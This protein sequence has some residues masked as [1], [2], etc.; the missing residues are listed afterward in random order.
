MPN[1][2]MS[3]D[4]TL[5]GVTFNTIRFTKG[6]PTWV[7]PAAVQEA[8]RFGA[9]FVED[10]AKSALNE[11][12]GKAPVEPKPVPQGQDL[13]DAVTPVFESLVTKNAREDFT[14]SGTPRMDVLKNLLQ[15]DI[16]K[17]DAEHLWTKFMQERTGN[18]L[19]SNNG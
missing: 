8:L 13:V 10:D 17:K 5:V 19:A 14:A 18:V 2:I 1:M 11:A 15:F 16:Q 7:S 9:E 4:F 12:L 3:R 6:E